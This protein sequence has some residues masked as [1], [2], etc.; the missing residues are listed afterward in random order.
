MCQALFEPF[1]GGTVAG[2]AEVQKCAKSGEA[3]SI[4][5]CTPESCSEPSVAEKVEQSFRAVSSCSCGATY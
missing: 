1:L 4:S 3:Y 5:G 2:M